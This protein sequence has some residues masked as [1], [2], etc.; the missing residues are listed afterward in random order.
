MC[1]PFTRTTAFSLSCQWSMDLLMICWSAPSSCALCLWDRPNWKLECNTRSAAELPRQHSR[2][3][4]SPAV[5]WPY[6]RFDEI[7]HGTLQELG[8]WLRS[9]RRRA[10]LLKHE[11]IVRL[12]TNVWKKTSLQQSFA[13][14]TCI[15]LGSWTILKTQC[16]HALLCVTSLCVLRCVHFAIVYRVL[17]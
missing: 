3:H 12:L 5:G 4:L 11:M 2:P 14:V 10:I 13:V 8:S 9:I 6:R 1:P 16:C 17:P 15:Y 7:Q